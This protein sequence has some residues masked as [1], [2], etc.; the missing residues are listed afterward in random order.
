MS[1]TYFQFLF[2][3]FFLAV[4]KNVI[5]RILHEISI[6][7]HLRV[8]H[9]QYIPHTGESILANFRGRYYWEKLLSDRVQNGQPQ[10]IL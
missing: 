6:N 1:S 2:I 9:K 8:L 10:Y 4:K 3:S 7:K 5:M